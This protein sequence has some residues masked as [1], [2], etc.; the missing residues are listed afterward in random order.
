MSI[1]VRPADLEAEA[2]Q[3]VKLLAAYVNPCYDRARFEWLYRRNPDGVA[4]AWL[5]RTG[6]PAP[7]RLSWRTAGRERHL[8]L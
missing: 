5:A 8:L 1:T 7:A 2:D 3:I 4:Q 6:S